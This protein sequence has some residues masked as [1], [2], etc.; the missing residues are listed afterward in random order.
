MKKSLLAL[1]LALGAALALTLGLVLRDFVGAYILTPIFFV[2]WLAQLIFA[3]IP[4]W[5]WWAW[6]LII[7]VVIAWRSLRVRLQD[8]EG[9][10]ERRFP[11]MGP[12]RVW[13]ERLRLTHRRND[14]F[15]W[16][17]ARD[18]ADLALQCTAPYE[19]DSEMRP[20]RD[21]DLAA[22][23]APPEVASYLQQGLAAAPWRAVKR[24]ERVTRLWRPKKALTP[25]DLDPQVAIAFLEGQLEEKHGD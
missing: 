4:G 19:R 21:Q 9:P 1:L 2:A 23:N 20:D 10:D 3:S 18:L 22:L 8:T 6:F 15:R 11:I 25:L 14:Y 24:W 16:Q 5:L 12:V 17:L 13:A 7:A